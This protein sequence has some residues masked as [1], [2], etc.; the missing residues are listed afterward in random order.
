MLGTPFTIPSHPVSSPATASS[1]VPC[2]RQHN[3]HPHALT[4]QLPTRR[5]S[6]SDPV[7]PHPNIN[8]NANLVPPNNAPAALCSLALAEIRPPANAPRPPLPL[9]GAPADRS[10]LP[11]I[12]GS[13]GRPRSTGMHALL[14]KA[15]TTPT[16]C[17]GFIQSQKQILHSVLVSGAHGL[18]RMGRIWVCS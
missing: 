10:R 16:L 8:T 14:I 18:S 13:L 11:A 3:P 2:P 7:G 12:F 4:H 6:T 15:L 9:L 17:I 1:I 5:T